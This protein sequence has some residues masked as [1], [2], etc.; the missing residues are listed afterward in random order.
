[1]RTA[2]SVVDSGHFAQQRVT[3][4]GRYGHGGA[5]A[6]DHQGHG[7]ALAITIARRHLSRSARARI[8][9]KWERDWERTLL[10]AARWCSAVLAPARF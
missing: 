3:F 5:A 4:P 9:M 7:P 10:A 6:A 8:V 2:G 1:M